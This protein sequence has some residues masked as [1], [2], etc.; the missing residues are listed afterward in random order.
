MNIIFV[1]EYLKV[2]S[3]MSY[4]TNKQK[5]LFVDIDLHLIKDLPLHGSGSKKPSNS[6]TSIIIIFVNKYLMVA[7]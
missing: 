6:S 5:I 7:V 2:S 4:W 1:N 3:L